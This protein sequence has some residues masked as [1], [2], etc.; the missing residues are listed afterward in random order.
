M[1]NFRVIPK[2]MSANVCQI[3]V[4]FEN[5]Q[6]VQIAQLHFPADGQMVDNV[7]CMRVVSEALRKRIKK[8]V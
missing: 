3:F 6:H 1:N 8:S 4:L 2:M 7:E 5:G